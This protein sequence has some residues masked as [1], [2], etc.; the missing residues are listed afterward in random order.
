MTI[1]LTPPPPPSGPLPRSASD[2]PAVVGPQAGR[3]APPAG[4]LSP[5]RPGGPRI[6]PRMRRRRAEAR[7]EEGRR[8]LRRLL[9]GFGVSLSAIAAVVVAHSPLLEVRHV[10]VFGVVHTSRQSVLDAAGFGPGQPAVPMVDVDSPARVAAVEALPW[11]RS[12]V[13]HRSWPWSVV[14]RVTERRPAALVEAGGTADVVDSTGRVLE[15]SKVLGVSKGSSL[16]TVNGQPLPVLR[17]ALTAPAGGYVTPVRG[18]SKGELGELER[19]AAQVPSSLASQGLVLRYR[20]GKGLV[21][22]LG[23]VSTT[24]FLGSARQVETKLEV[25]S[26]LMRT[27][28]LSA[29]SQVDLTVPMRPALD[30]TG[31]AA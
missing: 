28:N 26:E 11:V 29:Y 7:R 23:G 19:S 15:V 31:G 5:P 8:R 13:F 6:D 30:P 22:T 24:V 12:V 18:T 9:L 17:G 27:T 1:R 10:A 4:P 14:V 3:P 16:V 21:V 2:K 25:L 20:S